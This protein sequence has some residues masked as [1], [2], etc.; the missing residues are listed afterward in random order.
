[1]QKKHHQ[2]QAEIPRPQEPFEEKES[3]MQP[4]EPEVKEKQT[5][6][7]IL[8]LLF[9]ILVLGGVGTGYILS[10]PSGGSLGGAKQGVIGKGYG[11][12][13]TKTFSD[14]AIGTIEKDGVGGE[15]THK[16]IREGGPSQTACLVSSVLDL[17]EFVGKKVKVWSKTMDAKACPWLMDVGRI[18]PQ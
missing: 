17:N 11:S 2:P 6:Y 5:L 18:E 3:P 14:T 8:G 7:L 4:I 13:D 9:F 1:M 12:T 16:L 15:G 10:S